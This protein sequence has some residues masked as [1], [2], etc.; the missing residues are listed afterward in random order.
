MRYIGGKHWIKDQ[1]AAAILPHAHGR[2]LIEPFCGGLSATVAL[3]PQIA[4][5][6]S[7]PLIRLIQAIRSGW[8]PPEEVTEQMYNEVKVGPHDI[9]WCY[10]GLCCTW[11]GKW[12]GGYVRPHERQRQPTK[13]AAKRLVE[14]VRFTQS[15]QFFHRSYEQTPVEYGDVVYCD[16]PY[17]G[18]TTGWPGTEPFN[19]DQFWEWVKWVAGNGVLVF[20]SEF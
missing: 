14:Q 2:R 12:W 6:A 3:K 18:T 8:L 7:E 16:P 15:T 10:V 13:A 5:D 1:L 20:V 9:M 11:G 4:A 19:H 17:K